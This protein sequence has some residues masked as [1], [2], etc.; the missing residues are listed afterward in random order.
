MYRV[1]SQTIKAEILV[2]IDSTKNIQTKI[3]NVQYPTGNDL[4]RLCIINSS[5][6][7]FFKSL[8]EFTIFPSFL[9]RRRLREKIIAPN[10]P[11]KII[12]TWIN[13]LLIIS[14][15]MNP[16]NQIVQPIVNHFIKLYLDL[17]N[18]S[19]NEDSIISDFNVTQ[20]Y[21]YVPYRLQ[22]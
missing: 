2:N 15:N 6:S 22:N 8:W 12:N 9:N 5:F 11:I 20:S 17:S 13:L 16:P 14:F 1:I 4:F 19:I 21:L 10:N 18:F 7:A 3:I